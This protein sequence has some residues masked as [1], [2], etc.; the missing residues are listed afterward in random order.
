MDYKTGGQGRGNGWGSLF[1]WLRRTLKV[2]ARCICVVG[3]LWFR[4]YQ[5]SI[6]L[7]WKIKGSPAFNSEESR[8]REVQDYMQDYNLGQ[9]V[10]GLKGKE[11]GGEGLI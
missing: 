6:L 8:R 2:R 5:E 3:N 7:F 11:D 4:L 10:V 9:E 1:L